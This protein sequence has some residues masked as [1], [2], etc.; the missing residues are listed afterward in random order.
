MLGQVL[1]SPF[2]NSYSII[3]LDLFAD[4]PRLA[5]GFI[6]IGAWNIRHINVEAGA[7]T[8]LP[9]TTTANDSQILFRTF[10]KAIQDLGLDVV[11]VT[12]VKGEDRLATIRNCLNRGD[13][14]AP[15]R[16]A[17]TDMEFA[18]A[19]T[20]IQLSVVWNSA[21]VE[22]D[23][24]EMEVLED[25]RQKD[26]LRAPIR[27]LVTAG[28]LKFDLIVVHFNASQATPQQEKVD[29]MAAYFRRPPRCG[30]PDGDEVV[31]KNPSGA[32]ADD[33]TSGDAPSGHWF[34]LL[35]RS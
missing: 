11:A 10:A 4:E 25:Q 27:I 6:L 23:P 12:E 31:L 32:E 13:P 33:K 35:R 7:G 15:W 19:S 24:D 16:S 5:D 29:A 34:N 9:G 17:Q 28:A 2:A 14:T 18:P 3:D 30:Q 21:K 20:E 8:F 22:I 26:S 1:E